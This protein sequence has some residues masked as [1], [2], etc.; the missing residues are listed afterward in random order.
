MVAAVPQMDEQSVAEFWNAHPCGEAAVG[1]MDDDFRG[2]FD[3]YDA[4]RY[5]KEPHILKRLDAIDWRDKRVL[6]IGLG[7][8][9][10][11]EQL[12]R[13]GAL[14]SGVDLTEESVSRVATRL[15]V[16]GLPYESLEVASAR[17]LPF[18]D[19]QF[20]LVFS[21]GV[22][23]HIPDIDLAQREIARV[24][25]GNGRL[26][27]MLY[28]KRSLNYLLSI[29]VARRLA[30]A[31]LYVLPLRPRGIA[32][33]HLRLARETGLAAYLRLSAFVHRSTDGPLNPYSKVYDSGAIA[34]DFSCFR[35]GDVSKEFMY[36]PPL[37]VTKLPL[38][39][40]LGWHLWVTLEPVKG[41]RT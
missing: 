21:H 35:V 24:L 28:A 15:A 18:D 10:D 5:A 3:R 12:I 7:L 6:E 17:S 31:V 11:S 1:V 34:R 20:D 37:P 8:G 40:W 33:T 9:A 39:R 19:D 23:H 36:A 2:F 14:W 16:R 41:L 4:Y 13:R 29:A 30:L 22:L 26:I 38:A 25:K 32:G 27:A